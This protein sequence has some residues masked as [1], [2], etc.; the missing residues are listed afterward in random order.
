MTA[1][2]QDYRGIKEVSGKHASSVSRH[3]ALRFARE[4]GVG[5]NQGM[6]PIGLRI[7]DEKAPRTGQV[8]IGNNV[9]LSGADKALIHIDFNLYKPTVKADSI[10]HLKGR[11]L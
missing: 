3:D 4:F 9:H 11:I 10:I 5:I 1:S 2:P 6:K 7:W 8:A